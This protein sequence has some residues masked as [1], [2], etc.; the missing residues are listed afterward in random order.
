MEG[1][2]EMREHHKRAIDKLV[3]ELKADKRFIALIIGGS[4][5]KGREQ[6]NSDV[7]ILLIASDEEFQRRKSIKE[8]HYYRNDICDYP[9]G[10]I[11]G[12]VVDYQFILDVYER[13]SEPAR[14][15]FCG[16]FVAFSHIPEL[17]K[18]IVG[19]P[20]YQEHEQREKI[21]SFHAQVEALRWFIPEAEKREDIYLLAHTASELVLFGGRL[22]LAHNRILFPSHKWF[23]YEI[24]NA[25]EKPMNFFE[26]A[27]NLLKFPN[28]QN[29]NAFCEAILNFIVWEKP[30]EGW[31]GRF[32]EDSEWNWIDAK[33][34][35]QDR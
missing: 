25:R 26:L 7:D 14:A 18:I 13:G 9:D 31:V 19:I 30:P 4:I 2:Q 35:V 10:Y 6:E 1:G 8:Y 22:I 34:P 11:D 3:E 32:I 28:S 12:H 21:Y 5:A 29:S 17:E 33:A 23:M 15:Y 24:E 27:E 20:V 16:A